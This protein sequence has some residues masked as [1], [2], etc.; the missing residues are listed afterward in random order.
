[1]RLQFTALLI[2][3]S[4]FCACATASRVAP[5]HEDE[6]ASNKVTNFTV[7]VGQ[8]SLD[9]DD[10]E[11]VEDQ[12]VFGIEVDQYERD[13]SFGW[14]VA[15]QYSEDDG[16]VLGTDIGGSTTE[17]SFGVRKT[18]ATSGRIHPYIGAGISSMHAQ[19]DITGAP[20]D[21]DS[22][23]GGYAHG[24]VYWNLGQN[25]NVGVDVRTLQF[26]DINLNG[27]DA[28]ANYVQG[29]VTLGLAF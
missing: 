23:I 29:A 7:I 10:W 4:A 11:P 27:V 24:G 15:V 25:L 16:S 9:K 2:P 22:A 13:E 12:F 21:E 14:E 28:D 17:F 1:M 6:T 26:T 3:L 8:R 5:F 20:S 18:F 19:S